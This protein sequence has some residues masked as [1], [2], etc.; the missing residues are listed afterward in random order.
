MKQIYRLLTLVPLASGLVSVSD[1]SLAAE[2]DVGAVEEIVVTARKHAESLA[3]VPISLTAVSA[4]QIN[5]LGATSLSNLNTVIP[6]ASIAPN[7]SVVIR[8]IQSN[9]RNIGFE[10]GASIFVDGVYLGR[11]QLNN[12]DLVDVNQVEVLRG[13]QGSLY[14][15]NTTAGAINITTLRPTDS[16]VV[17]ATADYGEDDNRTRAGI[18]AAGPVID[19]L[20]GVKLAAFSSRSDG[21]VTNRFN[22][23]KSGND[24][25]Y[26]VRAELRLTPSER[27]DIALRA[28]WLIDDSRPAQGS[29]YLLPGSNGTFLGTVA[30]GQPGLINVTDAVRGNSPTSINEFLRDSYNH[31][32][33]GVSLTIDRTFD[34]GLDLVSISSYRS[35]RIDEISDDT[36]VP[37]DVIRHR[38]EDDTDHW[39]QELRLSSDRENRFRY[40]VGAFLFGQE[41]TSA[42]PITLGVNHVANALLGTTT[43]EF[44]NDVRLRTSSYAVFVNADYDL[45]DQLTANVGLRY[46]SEEKRLNFGQIGVPGVYPNLSIVDRFTDSDLSPTVSLIYKP[47]SDWSFYTTVSRGFKSGGWNPDITTTGNIQFGQE[48]VTNY[49]IGAHLRMWGGR[50]VSDVAIYHQDYKDMQVS[51]FLGQALGQVITNA[52]RSKIDGVEFSATA[53]LAHWLSLSSGV[54]YNHAEF[55]EYDDGMGHDYEGNQI[56]GSPRWSYFVAGDIH[57]PISPEVDF[58]ARTEFSRRGRSYFTPDNDNT[59]SSPL[60]DTLNVR[61]GVALLQGR[62]EILAYGDNLTDDV[63][64]QRAINQATGIPVRV[65]AF[66]QGR[67]LGVRVRYTN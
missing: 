27:W 66:N 52:G 54:G 49:E 8:G 61:L 31:D 55:S 6:N 33:G 65:V 39:S 28:D 21:Y 15:K 4:E 36:F 47:S 50:L 60:Q 64:V 45:L 67:V 59:F 37:F 18:A 40:V 34:N 16:L 1:S 14:G 17:R 58:I 19:E 41:A 48:N 24:D 9:T 25:Y 35:Q 2:N 22:G 11:P 3:D 62:L 23:Q 10:S 63:V 51:Q 38:F 44:R 56:Q 32:G 26:G 46:T 42:R 7:G 12:L 43:Y 5:K 13:P 57:Q 53:S 30:P 29:A 20:L